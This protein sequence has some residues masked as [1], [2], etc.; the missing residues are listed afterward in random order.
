[1]LALLP[2]LELRLDG[3]PDA[4]RV[5]VDLDELLR[6]FLH[7]VDAVVHCNAIQPGFQRR[8]TPER[9]EMLESFDENFL[10]QVHR[11][12]AFVDESVADPVNLPLIPDHD[13]VKSGHIA[14]EI[15]FD[16]VRVYIWI[17]QGH[18]H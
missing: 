14:G 11:I 6:M 16:Q 5:F 3:R 9:G 17:T 10:R 8:L 15:S 4:A 7:M 12:F 18:W 13:L 1:M 2:L